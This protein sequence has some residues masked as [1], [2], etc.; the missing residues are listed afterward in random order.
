MSDTRA[1]YIPANGT[2]VNNIIKKTLQNEASS[3]TPIFLSPYF[4][5]L[6]LLISI[7]RYYSLAIL[8]DIFKNGKNNITSI[9]KN[10]SNIN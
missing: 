7:V 9:I 6:I 4:Q 2:E 3:E 8:E 5:H 1:N 10:T